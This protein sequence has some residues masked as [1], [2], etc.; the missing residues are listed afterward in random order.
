MTQECNNGMEQRCLSKPTMKAASDSQRS[1]LFQ[2]IANLCRQGF[3]VLPGD[4]LDLIDD[5]YKEVWPRTQAQFRQDTD[6][7][8]DLYKAF[9]TF[10]RPRIVRTLRWRAI[11]EMPL[12]TK[13]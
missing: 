2:A 5:F 1:V 9:V 4:G 13:P 11:L 12:P 7:Q 3:P 8:A 6:S 10:A